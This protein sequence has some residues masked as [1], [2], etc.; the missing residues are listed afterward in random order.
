MISGSR[1]PAGLGRARPDFGVSVGA[2]QAAPPPRAASAR[3]DHVTTL[4]P[5]RHAAFD[6]PALRGA[7]QTRRAPFLFVSRAVLA[8]LAAIG[9]LAATH[10]ASAA[11]LRVAVV[12]DGPADRAVF[13]IDKIARQAAEVGGE[14]VEIRFPADKRFV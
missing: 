14:D 1:N 9:L 11:P 6:T 4:P 5:A 12:T 10:P 13:S 3:R 8:T 2:S 7:S